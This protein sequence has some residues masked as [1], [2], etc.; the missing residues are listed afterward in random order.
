VGRFV[1][2]DSIVPQV[3]NPQAWN[4][5]S[6]TVNNPLKYTDPSG[7]CFGFLGGVDTAFCAMVIDALLFGGTALVSIGFVKVAGDAIQDAARNAS[8]PNISVDQEVVAETAIVSSVGLPGL[9]LMTRK[10]QAGIGSRNYIPYNTRRDTTGRNPKLPDPDGPREVAK[11]AAIIGGI[12]TLLTALGVAFNNLILGRSPECPDGPIPCTYRPTGAPIIAPTRSVIPLPI[13][14][15]EPSIAPMIPLPIT[16]KPAPT[17]TPSSIHWL[18][19][20]YR[21]NIRPR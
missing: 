18:P 11:A 4:R 12:G 16:I 17:T 10:V 7:H 2:A 5:Y 15:I 3:E 20:A 21:G 6:Y 1:S 13:M 14:L 9:I 19:P 8:L